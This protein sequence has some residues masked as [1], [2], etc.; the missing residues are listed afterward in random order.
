[1]N[2]I[3]I[4]ARAPVG[5]MRGAATQAMRGHRRGAATKQMPDRRRAPLGC[6]PQQNA[7]VIHLQALRL[8][9]P[10]AP[11]TIH[12]IVYS[13]LRETGLLFKGDPR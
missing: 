8:P 7:N 11:I 9:L 10:I 5:Q 1:M 12:P 6:G 2:N 13:F 4:L 3:Y